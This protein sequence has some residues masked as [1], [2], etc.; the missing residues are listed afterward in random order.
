MA[1]SELP[2]EGLARMPICEGCGA[3]VDEAHV[4]RRKDRL[5][6]AA[7]FRPTQIKVL[8]LDSAPRGPEADYFY[9]AAKDRSVR[10]VAARMYFDEL[11]KTMGNAITRIDEILCLN[12]F[13]KYGF[14]VSY[15]V[16]CP[17]ENRGELHNALRKLAPTIVKRVQYFLQPAYIVPIS[18]A[19]QELIRLFGLVGWGD[20]LVLDKGGPFVDPYL[21]DPE[22]QAVFA[23]SFGN[24][25]SK[26]LAALPS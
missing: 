20:R 3:R 8:I 11:V 18:Q 2:G 19:T 6:L 25:I 26:A 15:A 4:Q 1:A 10:S 12:E 16:E 7:R 14:F 23:T 5:D 24:R 9:L 13:R 21:G 22:R 17:I